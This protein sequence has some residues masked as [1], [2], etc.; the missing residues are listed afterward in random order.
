MNS[1]IEQLP[2]SRQ[3]FVR[4]EGIFMPH[5]RKRRDALYSQSKGDGSTAR[6]VHYT[7][8][9]AALSIISSKRI[10]MRNT[11]CMS[12]YREVQHGHQML[13]GFFAD[14]HRKETF[15]NAIDTCAPGVAMEAI[16]LFDQWWAN[17]QFSTYISSVSEHDD[18]EDAHGRLSMWR[19]FGAST[20]RVAIVL[21]VPWF[22]GAS[23]ALNIS[24]SPVSYLKELESYEILSAIP[25]FVLDNGDFI[26]SVDRQIVLN[27]VFDMLVAN[28]T[29]LKHEGFHEER[30][31]RTIYAPQSS[32]SALMTS[33]IVSVS[34][35][36]QTVYQ[37]PLDRTVDNAVSGLDLANIFDRLI[38][39]PSQFPLAMH[40]A[41]TRTLT[42]IGVPSAAGH[43]FVSGIPIRS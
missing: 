24:F 43:V 26:R 13:V 38:I 29:C 41:F 10:W 30:E 5:M 20:A 22:T 33:E 32:P 17:I 8:A 28:V 15:I 6:F 2:E 3:I 39:G 34:G 4:L 42:D 27:S 21:N 14:K 25:R 12:D 37:L 18:T 36:P 7:T 35:V 9:E 1:L 11:T 23:E 31:W 16:A 40:E 19:A